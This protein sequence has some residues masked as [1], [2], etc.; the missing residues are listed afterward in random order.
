[1]RCQPEHYNLSPRIVL[2]LLLCFP[3]ALTRKVINYFGEIQLSGDL[4]K[5][6]FSLNRDQATS[7]EDCAHVDTLRV[8]SLL[9]ISDEELTVTINFQV[10]SAPHVPLPTLK[11]FNIRFLS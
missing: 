3:M 8:C 1:M 9:V 11:S 6:R 4:D 5:L 10:F 2:L 7:S